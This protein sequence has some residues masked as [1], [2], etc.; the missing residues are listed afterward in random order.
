M[1]PTFAF[2][3]FK[4]TGLIAVPV[5]S[6]HGS[7]TCTR[8]A[9]LLSGTQL[10]QQQRKIATPKVVLDDDRKEVDGRK[11]M[12]HH[13]PRVDAHE[14]TQKKAGTRTR[15]KEAEF[16]R[17]TSVVQRAE[18]TPQRPDLATATDVISRRVAALAGTLEEAKKALQK[19]T[20]QMRAAVSGSAAKARK[21]LSQMSESRH[22]SKHRGL[23][24]KTSEPHSKHKV[25][26]VK[27]QQDDYKQIANFLN[28]SALV[29]IPVV[30]G[31]GGVV[32]LCGV[33]CKQK[34]R[35]PGS[36][37]DE[38]GVIRI[39]DDNPRHSQASSS[40]SDWNHVEPAPHHS[41]ILAFDSNEALMST[42]C[43]KQMI[44]QKAAK[45]I[46]P[47]RP[48]SLLAAEDD[49]SDE[50]VACAI[51]HSEVQAKHT[52]E[53]TSE[54][55]DTASTGNLTEGQDIGTASEA[56]TCAEATLDQ[57]DV[58]AEAC[59]KAPYLKDVE[60]DAGLGQQR[61]VL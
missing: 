44:P 15:L 8:E 23:V 19:G 3:F 48:R 50:S 58:E 49:E 59:P 51:L 41:P 37:P 53:D 43:P 31:V 42:L 17:R 1:R 40:T 16:P 7:T 57:S 56:S 14:A 34:S 55:Q 61:G 26:L 52:L 5:S 28:R 36:R 25:S 54:P 12:Q 33:L 20:A 22:Q 4:F 60:A 10:L 24:S 45:I 39:R 38:A 29:S 46:C 9:D 13:A 32:A 11:S 30:F 47:K 21:E 35:S 27:S 6:G 2:L 18:E